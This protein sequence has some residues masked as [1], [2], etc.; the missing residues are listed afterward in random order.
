MTF[1]ASHPTGSGVRGRLR[2]E[3]F[4]E[5]LGK[6]GEKGVMSPKLSLIQYRIPRTM[7][8]GTILVPSCR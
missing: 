5:G 6:G 4:L 3:A 8:H 7:E 2:L 1:L